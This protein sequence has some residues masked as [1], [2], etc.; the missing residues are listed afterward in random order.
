[1]PNAEHERE[2][3]LVEHAN[4]PLAECLVAGGVEFGGFCGAVSG[5]RDGPKR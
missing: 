2:R 4:C 3:R 1:M 5:W